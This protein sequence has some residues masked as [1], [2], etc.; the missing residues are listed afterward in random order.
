MDFSEY[1]KKR[2][3]EA[4]QVT[5]DYLDRDED[6]HLQAKLNRDI[7]QATQEIYPYLEGMAGFSGGLSKI[8]GTAAKSVVPG[9]AR[10]TADYL[11]SFTN[12]AGVNKLQA[13]PGFNKVREFLRAKANSVPS[14]K[15]QEAHRI[16]SNAVEGREAA[17]L[18]ANQ[19]K[20]KV[21]DEQLALDRFRTDLELESHLLKQMDKEVEAARR[22]KSAQE[23]TIPGVDIAKKK[24]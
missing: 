4:E 3:P 5:K 7:E 2:F 6:A 17:A 1:L 15:S 22:A 21:S 18:R 9:I 16:A 20:P 14:L 23:A 12:D 13:I 19:A 24:K 8:G 11:E 10:K